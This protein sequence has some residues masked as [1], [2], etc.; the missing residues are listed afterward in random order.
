MTSDLTKSPDRYES[1]AAGLTTEVVRRRFRDL[2]CTLVI[3]KA[4]GANNNSKQQVFLANHLNNLADLPF[5][6]PQP[7]LGSSQKKGAPQAIFHCPLT[8]SWLTPYGPVPAPHTKLIYY[9]QYPEVRLSG[10]LRD[11]R[12]APGHLMRI[13][14]RGKEEGR[15]LLLGVNPDESTV[16]GLVVGRDCP[17]VKAVEG[18]RL[19]RR[20]VLMTWPIDAPIA[21]DPQKLLLAELC[22]IAQRGWVRSQRLTRDGLKP[23]TAENGGGYTVESLLGIVSN[24]KAAPDHHGYEVK[25][26]DVGRLDRPRGKDVTLFDVVPDGGE[27]TRLGAAE[28]I[29]TF[30]HRTPN[31]TRYDFTG[32]HRVGHPP[33]R[34][35]ATLQILGYDGSNMRADGMVAVVGANGDALMEWSFAKLIDHWGRKHALAVYVPCEKRKS[36]DQ[37]GPRPE[38]RYGQVVMLGTGTDFTLFLDAVVSG[39]I[40]Y[41]PGMH[42]H[43]ASVAGPVKVRSLFR[44]HSW[45]L[46]LLYSSFDKVDACAPAS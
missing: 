22:L 39:A 15:L 5:G 6:S 40:R 41:D 4:M 26:F 31:G 46:H 38:Y 32:R 3:V 30:G 18:M 1:W 45:S 37:A 20:G 7:Q 44:I 29:R 2:G 16:F 12:S 43:E 35:G 17:L 27:Y 24:A 19:E 8:F 13:E 9:P 21:K 36:V 34:T 42:A 25:S 10:F 14:E 11:C 33:P 28:F 23:Y